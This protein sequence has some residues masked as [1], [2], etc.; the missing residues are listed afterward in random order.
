MNL[1][2]MDEGIKKH[3]SN[4]KKFAIAIFISGMLLSIYGIYAGFPEVA[5]TIGPS[6]TGSA[7]GLYINKQY[8]DRKKLESNNLKS[9]KNV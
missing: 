7:V 2:S 5:V 4:S 1:Y 3:R 9:G 8:Q 6:F